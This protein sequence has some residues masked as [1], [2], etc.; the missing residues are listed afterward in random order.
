MNDDVNTSY[1]K[2]Y[3]SFIVKFGIDSVQRIKNIFCVF[4]KNDRETRKGQN[5]SWVS[6]L[7]VILKYGKYY[8]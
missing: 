5:R 1:S 6:N 4:C 8:V 2:Y 3:F 7:P